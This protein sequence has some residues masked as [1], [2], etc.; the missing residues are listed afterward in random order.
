MK[1]LSVSGGGFQ[2]LYN[3]ILLEE[4]EKRAG[5]VRDL[6]LIHI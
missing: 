3:V 5:P 1:I 4:L 2:A 6:S